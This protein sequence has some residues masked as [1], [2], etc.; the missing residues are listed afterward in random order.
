MKTLTCFKVIILSALILSCTQSIEDKLSKTIGK[1]NSLENYFYH[2][3]AKS[4]NAITQ[5]WMAVF[6]L[7][8]KAIND[9]TDTIIGARFL[10]Y[11]KD[12][13]NIMTNYHNYI[14]TSYFPQNKTAKI[15]TI[16]PDRPSLISP[17]PIQAL[18]LLNYYMRNKDSVGMQYSDYG[19]SS[20]CIFTIKN[21]DVFFGSL[22]PDIIIQSNI[23]SKYVLWIN[24]EFLPYRLEQH[25]P[26]SSVIEEIK[27]LPQIRASE[28]LDKQKDIYLPEGYKL[29]DNNSHNLIDENNNFVGT[30]IIDL[31][32]ESI[33]GKQINLATLK[34]NLLIEFT[35][36]SCGACKLAIP[37]LINFSNT[38]KD[39]GFKVISIET[40]PFTKDQLIEYKRSQKFEYEYLMA[41]KKLNENYKILGTPIFFI[42]NKKG[43]IQKVFT[44]Y[45]KGT[46]DNKIIKFANTL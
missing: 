23:I 37:F 1:I 41:N 12:T 6:S 35:S 21:K 20:K 2:S 14:C 7:Y 13:S 4:G 22:K 32:L 27:Y 5:E 46:T 31:N 17:M 25:L 43:I 18:S 40:Y 36:K 3:S 28:V 26:N 30:K 34:N 8:M 15:D 9:P 29:V 39:K 10:R 16:N 42:V 11:D 44:G 24:K 38:Y 45:A 19:D 33:E